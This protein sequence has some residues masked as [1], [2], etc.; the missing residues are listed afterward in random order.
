MI[1]DRAFFQLIHHES[2]DDRLN[3]MTLAIASPLMQ[4]CFH[5]YNYWVELE[6]ASEK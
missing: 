6:K 2:K 4:L 3:V 5:V 1:Y